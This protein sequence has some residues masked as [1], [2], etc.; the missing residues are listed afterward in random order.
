MCFPECAAV[1]LQTC[2]F[3]YS[4]YLHYCVHFFHAPKLFI[5]WIYF[6]FLRLPITAYI[7]VYI[8]CYVK[9]LSKSHRC[10][11]AHVKTYTI[12]MN[13][14]DERV[15]LTPLREH[16]NHKLPYRWTVLPYAVKV[17]VHYHQPKS[18]HVLDASR[19]TR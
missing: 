5:Y 13:D 10:K 12:R 7:S 16:N 17:L 14:R 6:N 15:V 19:D 18:Q 2:P 3:L 8:T 4:S 9:H 11:F 1:N